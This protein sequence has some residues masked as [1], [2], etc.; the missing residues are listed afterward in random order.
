[1]TT[2]RPDE[3]HYAGCPCYEA[4][5]DAELES[6]RGRLARKEQER[7]AALSALEESRKARERA[8]EDYRAM[9]ERWSQEETLRRA[10]EEARDMALDEE[11]KA[12]RERDAEVAKREAVEASNAAMR[13]V[14]IECIDDDQLADLMRES[15]TGP[16]GSTLGRAKAALESSPAPR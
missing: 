16:R 11:L 4:S 8:Q 2:C 5:R 3:T 6:L 15:D 1:M 7:D 9:G 12:R 10:A 14:L 13:A